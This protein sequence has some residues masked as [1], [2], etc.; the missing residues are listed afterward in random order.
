MEK[1]HG[2]QR[3]SNAACE[4]INCHVLMLINYQKGTRTI[5]PSQQHNAPG[6]VV[7]RRVLL[8][9]GEKVTVPQSLWAPVA[10]TPKWKYPCVMGQ[11]I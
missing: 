7:A 9:C 10:V 3:N 1:G 2:A 11:L 4:Q 5:S 6:R 8:L